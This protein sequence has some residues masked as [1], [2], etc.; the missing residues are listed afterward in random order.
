M[1]SVFLKFLVYFVRVW[2]VDNDI[3]RMD[4]KFR[5][6][7]EPSSQIKILMEILLFCGTCLSTVS[8]KNTIPIPQKKKKK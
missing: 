7:L 2:S 5:Y 8:V 6:N 3:I 1:V 4:Y